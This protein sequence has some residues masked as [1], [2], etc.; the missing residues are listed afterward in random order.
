VNCFTN[1]DE[2]E[3]FLNGGSL[4]K[5]S[6]TEAKNRTLFWNT[7]YHPGELMVKGYKDG[8]ETTQYSLNTAGKATKIATSIYKDPLIN[9]RAGVQQIEV[10]LTDD[11]GQKVYDADNAVTVSIR[12]AATLLGIENSEANDVSD[13]K[14]STRK[15]KHGVLI[16]YVQP[17]AKGGTYEVK[18]EAAGME[19][20]VLVFN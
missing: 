11:K 15:A 13:Y 12:G 19:P 3:L 10:T 14:A 9:A 18:L 6:I 17:P 1:C 7:V 4:G 20:V 2:A 16:V 8:K 5:K